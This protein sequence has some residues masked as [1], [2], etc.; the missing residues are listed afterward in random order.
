MKPWGCY[1][2]YLT[3]SVLY[4]K[5]RGFL[6]RLYQCQHCHR[7]DIAQCVTSSAWM[8]SA[9]VTNHSNHLHLLTFSSIPTSE[10]QLNHGVILPYDLSCLINYAACCTS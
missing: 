6:F 1:G 2:S 7:C 3:V 10:F 8:I 4:S 5:T 9:V